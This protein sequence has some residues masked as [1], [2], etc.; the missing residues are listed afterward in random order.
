MPIF[1][2]GPG[3]KLSYNLHSGDSSDKIVLLHG[4][5][6]NKETFKEKKPVRP[7]VM[8]KGPLFKTEEKAKTYADK[9]R[10]KRDAAGKKSEE[11]K[12]EDKE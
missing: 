6:A 9:L 10:E 5:G 8:R 1:E 2:T 7:L 3:I 12:S 4:L 11:K